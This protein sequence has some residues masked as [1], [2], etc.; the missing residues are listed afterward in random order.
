MSMA[1]RDKVWD[2]D[3]VPGGTPLPDWAADFFEMIRDFRRGELKWNCSMAELSSFRVGGVAQAAVFPRSLNELSHL[4]QGMREMNLPWRVIGR[5]T[6]ILVSDSGLEGVV[7]VLGRDFCSMEQIETG[8]SDYVHVRVMAGCSLAMVISRCAEQGL[9]GLEFAAGIP[10]SVGGATA[11]NAGAFGGEMADV[12][13]S[14]IIMDREGICRKKRRNEMQPVYRSWNEGP[15]M[16]AVETIFK[17]KK[18]DPKTIAA[19]CRE[20]IAQRK[21]R[22]P[23]HAMSCGSFF[24]N[25]DGMA[26]G[27]LIE[28]AGLKGFQLGG[29]RV[30]EKHANFI[31]NT[32]TATA[33]DI[34]RLME[35]IRERVLVKSG[36]LLEPEV[37]L[38]GFVNA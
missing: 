38:L 11:M 3:D 16:T 8:G 33:A 34:V 7:V 17:L 20:I 26:A 28:E 13:S 22:Q 9:S 21:E 19:R 30:S 32:G 27:K 15:D 10:G 23:W 5:G 1:T 4:V 18:T 35:L 6:N 25:P 29:A 36:F 24:K 14:V 12:L 37:K 31:V 2:G